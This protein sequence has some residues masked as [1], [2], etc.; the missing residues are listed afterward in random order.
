MTIII[1][2]QFCS[3]SDLKSNTFIIPL[4]VAYFDEHFSSFCKKKKV[5]VVF[6]SPF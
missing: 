4:I 6:H 1:Y 2:G 5:L 3:N